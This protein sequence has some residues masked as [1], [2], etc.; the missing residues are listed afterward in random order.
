M[1]DVKVQYAK[2]YFFRKLML[3]ECI[4]WGVKQLLHPTV[5]TEIARNRI[6]EAEN[7]VKQMLLK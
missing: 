3:P 6:K 2:T 4:I 1:C 7:S 5:S